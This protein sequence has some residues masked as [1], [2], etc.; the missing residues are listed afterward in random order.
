MFNALVLDRV[1]HPRNEGPLQDATHIGQIG[2]EGDGPFMTLWFYVENQSVKNAAYKTYGCPASIASGSVIAE[3][4][5]GRNVSQV[6]AV[7]EG[8]ISLLLGGL[9]EE[10][11]DCARM[12]VNAVRDAFADNRVTGS[13]EPRCN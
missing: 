7:S 2:I 3:I 6:L 5:I 4:A 10:K 8:D 1:F 12:A 9:P 13:P 11:L